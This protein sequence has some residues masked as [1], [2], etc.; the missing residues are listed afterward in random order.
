MPKTLQPQEAAPTH[1]Y[2]K[3]YDAVLPKGKGKNLD[4]NLQHSLPDFLSTTT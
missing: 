4:V 2:F 3:I 1:P